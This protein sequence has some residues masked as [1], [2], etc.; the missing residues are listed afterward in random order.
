MSGRLVRWLMSLAHR[1]P[2]T[3]GTRVT[4]IRHHRVFGGDENPL[5]RLG[6]GVDVFERQL[7]LLERL[8]L[9]PLTVSALEAYWREAEVLAAIVDGELTTISG[10]ERLRVK[11]AERH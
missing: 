4:I 2:V 6:V 3:G 11:A 5:Y 8:A 7:A 9:Q 1:P 10:V